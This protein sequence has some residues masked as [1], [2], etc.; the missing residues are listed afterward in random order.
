[1]NK[2]QT[3]KNNFTLSRIILFTIFSLILS[4]ISGCANNS[5]SFIVINNSP[6]NII[7]PLIINTKTP[8]FGWQIQSDNNDIAQSAYQIEIYSDLS[9][10]NEKIWDSGKV[11][12]N[13]SQEIRP[14]FSKDLK[15]GIRYQWRVRVW[16]NNDRVSSWSE[17]TSFRIQPDDIES[18]A[19]WISAIRREDSNIPE[20]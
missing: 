14:N 13:Q 7:S 20:G 17:L 1:M 10:R 11:L 3:K 9:G 4:N 12:S 15:T 8:D 16:D 2:Q 19:N 6:G 5:R 18:N